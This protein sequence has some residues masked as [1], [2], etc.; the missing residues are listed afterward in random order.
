MKKCRQMLKKENQEQQWQ[1]RTGLFDL[2]RT[3]SFEQSLDEL[4]I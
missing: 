1:V 3:L 4:A 2:Y